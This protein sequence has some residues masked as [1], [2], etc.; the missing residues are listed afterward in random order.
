MSGSISNITNEQI[1][2]WRIKYEQLTIEANQARMRVASHGKQGRA[3]GLPVPA[4]IEACRKARRFP[5]TGELVAHERNVMRGLALMNV[6]NLQQD[7]FFGWTLDLAPDARLEEARWRAQ[8]QGYLAGMKGAAEDA[9]PQLTGDLGMAWEAGRRAGILQREANAGPGVRAATA[10]RKRPRRQTRL[11]GTEHIQH[12][13]APDP[14]K[15]EPVSPREAALAERERL[16]AAQA[17]AEAG[18]PVHEP[19]VVV[20]MQAAAEGAVPAK[21]KRGRPPGSKNRP[22][23]KISRPGRRRGNGQRIAAP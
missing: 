17:A 22:K 10:S 12:K 14:V 5:E 11:P 16:R 6:P 23:R 3:D 15:V 9:G 4:L 7:L 18:E 2:E 20:R 21:R 19:E 13:D 1:V 8:H